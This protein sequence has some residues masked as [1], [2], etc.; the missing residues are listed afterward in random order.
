MV[1]PSFCGVKR[2]NL[3][4]LKVC[5]NSKILTYPLTGSTINKQA[6]INANTNETH[7]FK[8]K[9]LGKS[10]KIQKN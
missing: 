7:N 9:I 6:E 10:E 2:E 4:I 1:H 8:I 5:E 3:E